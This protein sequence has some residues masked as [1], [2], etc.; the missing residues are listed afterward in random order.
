M[1]N[2]VRVRLAYGTCNLRTQRNFERLAKVFRIDYIGLLMI[3][4]CGS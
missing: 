2:S 4:N 1:E 3:N